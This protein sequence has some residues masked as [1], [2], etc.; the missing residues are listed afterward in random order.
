MSLSDLAS[1]GSFAS[2]AAVLVSLIYLALQVRQAERSQ[3]ALVQQ[4]RV[5]RITDLFVAWAQPDV[6]RLLQ[7]IN[8]TGEATSST[9]VFQ[10]LMLARAHV[11]GLEDSYLQHRNKQRDDESFASAAAAIRNAFVWPGRR[12]SWLLL[13]DSYDPGFVRFVEETIKEAP[14]TP[15]RDLLAEWNAAM[16]DISAIPARSPG[17]RWVG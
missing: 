6:A 5:A 9:E 10:Y 2:G 17:T 11:F 13:R 7:Q 12:A 3:R 14:V 1:L 16:A 4:T 15:G 8:A